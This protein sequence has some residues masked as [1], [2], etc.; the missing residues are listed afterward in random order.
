MSE[1]WAPLRP[2]GAP[3]AER[4]SVP[5]YGIPEGIDGTLPWTWAEE[6]LAAAETYWVAT[7]R[8]DGRPH[9]VPIW[10]AWLDGRLWFEGGAATRRA[11]DIA[12]NP[13]I[14]ISVE[15]PVDGAVI[16]EGHAERRLG[17]PADLAPRLVDAFAKYATPP[18]D[19]RADPANW[20]SPDGG[21]WIV[22]PR[23]V[24]GWSSF[25]ADATRWR[26]DPA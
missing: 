25:P 13:A 15:V 12:G 2:L 9:L 1:G 8:P 11:R 10:A 4:P 7:A 5:S 21:I 22:T 24:L 14:S 18:R 6:R 26:F 20:A 19:Y 17:V 23:I 16:V 3:R